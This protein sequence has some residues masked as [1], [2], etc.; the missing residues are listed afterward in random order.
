[1]KL[2]L[3]DFKILIKIQY[4]KN[5]VFL[6]LSGLCLLLVDICFGVDKSSGVLIPTAICWMLLSVSSFAYGYFKVDKKIIQSIRERSIN[7]IKYYSLLSKF[8][9]TN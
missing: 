7:E 4:Y 5:N 1:M 8:N 9:K 6:F 3:K 2:L